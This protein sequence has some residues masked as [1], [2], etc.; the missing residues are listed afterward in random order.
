MEPAYFHYPVTCGTDAQARGISQAFARSQALNDPGDPRQLVF[1]VLPT[2][3]V[4]IAEKWV[5]DKHPFQ[6]IWEYFDSGYLVPDR[7]V[8]QGPLEY[9]PAS[10]KMVLN[11]A[12]GL[13]SAR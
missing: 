12:D 5:P 6:T 9:R 7:H 11:R 2:H 3:G 4:V 10:E 1:T 13:S 8:P